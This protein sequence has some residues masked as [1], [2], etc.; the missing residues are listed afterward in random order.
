MA[1]GI[2]SFCVRDVVTV[3]R[4]TSVVE[5]AALIMGGHSNKAKLLLKER[6]AADPEWPVVAVKRA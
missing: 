2:G 1:T 5:A 6:V 3:T 4:E